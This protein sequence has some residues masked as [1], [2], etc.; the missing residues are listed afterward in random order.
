MGESSDR[1]EKRLREINT[2]I[3]CNVKMVIVHG[4][5]ILSVCYLEF[6][7]LPHVLMK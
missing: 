5:I 4:D 7:V 6:S 2:N 1:R 3:G